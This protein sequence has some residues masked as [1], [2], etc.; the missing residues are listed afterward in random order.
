MVRWVNL[1]H[2]QRSVSGHR[3]KLAE[4]RLKAADTVRAAAKRKKGLS[5]SISDKTG[6]VKRVVVL[7][8]GMTRTL[9]RHM[10]ASFL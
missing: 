3:R 5:S 8:L 1:S 6:S 7:G 2:D 9:L 4:E 10:D